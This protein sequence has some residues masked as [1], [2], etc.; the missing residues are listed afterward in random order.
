MKVIG[1][2]IF[3]IAICGVIFLSFWKLLGQGIFASQGNYAQKTDLYYDGTFHDSHEISVMSEK[4]SE[5]NN[6][7]TI[8][9]RKIRVHKLDSTPHADINDLK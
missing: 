3:V 7:Q 4:E 6:E 1:I 9:D 2:I 8:L 5:F